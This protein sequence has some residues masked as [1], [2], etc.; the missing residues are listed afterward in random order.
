MGKAIGDATHSP[1]VENNT[2]SQSSGDLPQ[3]TGVEKGDSGDTETDDDVRQIT[4]FCWFLICAAL[5][6][7]ALMYGL[8]TTIAADMQGAVIQRF[9]KVDKLAWIRAAFPLRLVS[10]ILPYGFLFM[11]FNMKWLYIA[12]IVLFQGGSALCGGTPNMGALIVR[13][14]IAGAGGTGIYLG[15]LNHLSA[16]TTQ[17]ECGAYLA[18]TGFV[19]GMGVILGPVVGGRF[20]DS[21]ATWRWGFYIN[22]IIGAITGPVYLFYRPAIH[23][24]PGKSFRD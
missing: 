18:R 3:P 16:M 4:G 9:H 24:A 17:T 6:L 5:Y 13:C 14:V 10:V 12:G 11:A 20:S 23:P 22:L 19:W 15:G 7:S 1:T 2:S 21:S 8:D